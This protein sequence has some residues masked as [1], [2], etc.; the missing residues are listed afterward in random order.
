[1]LQDIIKDMRKNK[2]GAVKMESKYHY[3]IEVINQKNPL[4]IG[5]VV[6]TEK[7]VNDRVNELLE[8]GW[9]K[10]DI[11]IATYITD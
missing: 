4:K 7:E 11:K 10:K 9:D 6:H 5:S 8:G 2:K 1:M 3:T